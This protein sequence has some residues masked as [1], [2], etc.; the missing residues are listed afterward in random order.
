MLKNDHSLKHSAKVCLFAVII[1]ENR[2]LHLDDI[3][4]LMIA[5][6]F[7]D[8]GRQNNCNDAKHGQKSV[9]KADGMGY[10]L[11]DTVKNII[12]AH[13]RADKKNQNELLS[14][15]KD[16]DALDRVRTGD[17]DRSKLRFE[18][19]KELIEFA[20]DLHKCLLKAIG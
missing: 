8:I 3:I 18:E 19:S 1:A 11:S 20:E 5:S 2:G 15:F 12:I 16:A 17:L 10:V 13:S 14:I 7:H 9:L 4:N 6:I